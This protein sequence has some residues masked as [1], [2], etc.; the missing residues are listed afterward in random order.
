M[1][2]FIEANN[3]YWVSNDV[4]HENDHGGY[5]WGQ[6]YYKD[7]YNKYSYVDEVLGV[8]PA[9][10]F[11]LA[12]VLFTSAADDA[13][14]DA[15]PGK[16]VELSDTSSITRWKFTVRDSSRGIS[17]STSS[18]T[19]VINGYDSWIVSIAF[20]GGGTDTNDY[21]SAILCNPDGEAIYYA[22]VAK[23]TASGTQ[24][25]VMPNDLEPG[26]YTLK[27]F[28][29]RRNDDRETDY[30]SEFADTRSP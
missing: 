6:S 29:E 14:S 20:S 15:G 27:V 10:D 11:S 25:M 3:Y 12:N 2:K 5:W 23:S 24:D 18:E 22:T 9:T 28:S 1:G 26:E 13:K 7:G 4:I 30:P 8:R 19:A 17:A 21:V 16:F